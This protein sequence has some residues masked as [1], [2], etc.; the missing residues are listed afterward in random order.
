LEYITF[1]VV[2]TRETDLYRLTDDDATRKKR[3][4]YFFTLFITASKQRRPLNSFPNTLVLYL[5]ND[6]SPSDICR[7]S[8]S[9]P[10]CW[11]A[12]FHYSRACSACS[13]KRSRHLFLCTSFK[14]TQ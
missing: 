8:A 4:G 11:D 9:F 14:A 12:T 1:I 6:F 13:L 7:S 2:S 10:K 3:K 5:W